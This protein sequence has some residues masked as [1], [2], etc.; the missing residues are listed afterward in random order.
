LKNS[1]NINSTTPSCDSKETVTTIE[2]A[3]HDSGIIEIAG[4][5]SAG[6]LMSS[7]DE[8]IATTKDEFTS[9]QTTP[10]VSKADIALNSTFIGG[11]GGEATPERFKRYL[12]ERNE[13]IERLGI[14]FDSDD[15]DNNNNNTVDGEDDGYLP[16]SDSDEQLLQSVVRD[17]S[18][19]LDSS[20]SPSF[21][22]LKESVW[23]KISLLM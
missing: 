2:E 4:T 21:S 13:D 11:V 18:T 5:I 19:I 23:E 1:N 22:S 15:G 6:T 12:H 7:R 9:T 17:L 16:E 10:V 14:S 3:Y 20:N 8:V